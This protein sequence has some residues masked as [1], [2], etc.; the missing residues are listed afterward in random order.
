[1]NIAF[2]AGTGGLHSAENLSAGAYAQRDLDHCE[3]ADVPAAGLLGFASWEKKH[4][5]EK[6][7]AD[8]AAAQAAAAKAKLRSPT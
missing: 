1:M 7:R 6:V 5:V 2:R 3:R 4:E 8:L